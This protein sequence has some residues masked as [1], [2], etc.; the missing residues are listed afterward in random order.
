MIQ[1]VCMCLHC[2]A[3]SALPS[4]WTKTRTPQLGNTK[5]RCYDSYNCFAFMVL[6]LVFASIYN[7]LWIYLRIFELIWI[8][9]TVFEYDQC[10]VL[11]TQQDLPLF[12]S[13]ADQAK[14]AST[15]KIGNLVEIPTAATHLLLILLNTNPGRL[16]QIHSASGPL[17]TMLAKG[18]EYLRLLIR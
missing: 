11:W 5:V 6:W 8:C 2:P 13:S 16:I 14:V 9:S 18:L 12:C 4:S 1:F 7:D 15:S 17:A 10:C 3:A